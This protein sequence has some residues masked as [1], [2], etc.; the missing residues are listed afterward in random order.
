ME[1]DP[2]ILPKILP[3]V[4]HDRAVQTW[5]KQDQGTDA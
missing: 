4:K 3:L 2:K 5:M 1:I